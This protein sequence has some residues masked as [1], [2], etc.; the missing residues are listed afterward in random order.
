MRQDFDFRHCQ[1]G[2]AVEGITE[3]SDTDGVNEKSQLRQPC[4]FMTHLNA[5]KTNR[6]PQG[7]TWFA[8]TT[9]GYMV[10]RFDEP[11]YLKFRASTSR[12]PLVLDD[13]KRVLANDGILAVLLLDYNEI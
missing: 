5:A 13:Q 8:D 4:N 1:Q 6:S 9:V 3:C 10:T 2:A 12:F 7:G 11:L